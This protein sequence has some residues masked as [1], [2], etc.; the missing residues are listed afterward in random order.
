MATGS[1]TRAKRPA[2]IRDLYRV[3]GKA[4]LVNGR[5]VKMSPTGDLP[6]RVAYKIVLSL[7]S[8]EQATKAG[9]VY[10]DN[11]AFVVHLPHRGSFSPDVSY[12]TGPPPADP[13]DFLPA[14]PDFAVEVRSKGDYGRT[15]ER[16]MKAKRADYFAAGTKVVWD[17]DPVQQT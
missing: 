5:I 4:E 2:T 15:A 7:S 1:K 8:Y 6:S 16:R 9:K 10:T 11:V 13:F 3:E 17:V 12:Y 14:P